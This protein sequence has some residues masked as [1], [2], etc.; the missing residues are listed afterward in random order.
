[1]S[2][3]ELLVDRHLVPVPS[4]VGA[5]VIGSRVHDEHR[6]DSDV[7]CVLIFEDVDERVIPGEFVWVPDDDSFH[8][9]FEVEADE[10]GGAQV[11]AIGRR[12]GWVEF[13][14][15][16]WPEG[17]T[18]DL[19]RS[20]VV[21]ERGRD[22]PGLIAR[23]T[24]Y[25]EDLRLQRLGEATQW[26]DYHL[27]PW[28]LERWVPRG[29]LLCAHDQLDACLEELIAALHAYN[30][31]WMPWRYRRLASA[32][33]LPWL[34]S[35]FEGRV[36]AL[37]ADSSAASLDARSATLRTLQAELLARLDEDGLGDAVRIQ[38]SLPFRGL[39]FASSMDAWREAHAQW[40]SEQ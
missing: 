17:L 31:T 11:D 25:D 9:I 40:V 36:E 1:M 26:L 38:W 3:F 13:S 14:E 6:A 28:R 37:R 18:H 15:E 23:R 7:D 29:G 20:R 24:R 12:V 21:F 39:G 22:V 2:L 10:V 19:A 33:K 27:T 5:V 34:P 16:P 4:F 32:L 35:G 30:R 8:S